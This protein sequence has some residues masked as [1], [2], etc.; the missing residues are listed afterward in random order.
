MQLLIDFDAASFYLPKTDNEQVLESATLFNLEPQFG[1]HYLEKYDS[2]DYSRGLMFTGRSMAY[3]ESDI[4][5]DEKRIH[6][7]YYQMFYAPYNFHYSM[8]L[9]IAFNDRFLGIVSF[10]RDKS[11]ENFTTEDIETLN[12]LTDHLEA[13]LYQDYEKRL[14]SYE[15]LTVH[16]AAGK[17]SLTKREEKVMQSLLDGMENE[18]ICDVLCIT[19]NTLKKHI[20]NIYR[21]LDINNRVQLFKMIREHE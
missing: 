17:Y 11:K 8:H 21:K 13:R 16:E 15:K 9:S 2:L 19:N 5:P 6:S 4:I 1:E 20:L 10:F 14:S 7:E 12:L 3:R 18:E